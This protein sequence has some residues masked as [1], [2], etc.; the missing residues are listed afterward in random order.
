MYI[1][2]FLILALCLPAMAEKPL[3]SEILAAPKNGGIYVVCHRGAHENTPENTLAA[4]QRAIDLGA[5]YVEIDTRTTKDGQIVSVHNST[6]DSYTKDAKGKVA[7]FT[8]AE[9]KAMDIGSRVDVKW[10]DERIPTFEEI[11]T[12]CKGKIGIYLDLKSADVAVL[13]QMVKDHGMEKDVIWYCDP[14]EH[15]YVK[16]HGG[17]SMPDPGPEKFLA[18]MLVEYEPAVV[19]SVWEYF[20]PTFVSKCHE[21]GA[22]VIVD[23]SDPSCWDDALAWGTD[24]IQTDHPEDF[25]NYLKK[26]AQSH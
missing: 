9:L 21:A 18:E 5:D 11:L 7:D 16:E 12:L 26:R 23:E 13:F 2:T 17:I 8:L 22:V 3:V 6:V 1:R 10:K 24:G 20:S 15:K 4:Y 25:I 19:A 14:E